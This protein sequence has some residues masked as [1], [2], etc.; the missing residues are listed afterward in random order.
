MK[1]FRMYYQT[2]LRRFDHR[3]CESLA[4]GMCFVSAVLL[5]VR[6]LARSIT[7][8]AFDF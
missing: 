1:V 8:A 6:D 7:R 5:I 3:R 2:Q 4:I